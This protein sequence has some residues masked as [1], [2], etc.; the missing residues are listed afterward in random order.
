LKLAK[1]AGML[2]ATVPISIVMG[3]F[4]AALAGHNIEFPFL[5]G[6]AIVVGTAVAGV[7]GAVLL[8]YSKG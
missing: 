7:L 2:L 4:A 6:G 5:V 1:I 3:L 8:E